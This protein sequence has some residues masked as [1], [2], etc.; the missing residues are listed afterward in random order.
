M[1]VDELLILGAAPA[2]ITLHLRGIPVVHRTPIE[3]QSI[4][5]RIE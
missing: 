1:P 5:L 2:K 3:S 4:L